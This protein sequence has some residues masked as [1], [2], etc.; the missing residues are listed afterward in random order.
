MPAP[1][2]HPDVVAEGICAAAETGKRDVYTGGAS[3]IISLMNHITPRLLDFAVR[4]QASDQK[5]GTLNGHAKEN[6]A[7]LNAPAKEGKMRGGHKGHVMGTSLYTKASIH[8]YVT[9]ATLLGL[10][11]LTYTAIA[12]RP[13]T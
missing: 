5:R 13:R 7:L 11:A 6:E 3:K 2:Y 10:A 8:P 4:G 1:V 12:N 9:G